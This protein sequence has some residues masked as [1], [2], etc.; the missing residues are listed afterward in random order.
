MPTCGPTS[1]TD[2]RSDLVLSC[3]DLSA[4]GDMGTAGLGWVRE[5]ARPGESPQVDEERRQDLVPDDRWPA[6]HSM[7]LARR[8][9]GRHGRNDFGPGEMMSCA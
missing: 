3:V 6:H 4:K 2:L 9:G 1:C 7:D 8:H 5:R